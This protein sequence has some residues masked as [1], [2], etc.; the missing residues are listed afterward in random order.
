M[1]K[2]KRDIERQEV[3]LAAE[4]A[5]FELKQ[6]QWKLDREQELHKIEAD[7]A[8]QE[9]EMEAKKMEQ[10]AEME[11]KKMA[12]AAKK[13]KLQFEIAKAMLELKEA[14]ELQEL[15]NE[16]ADLKK[17]KEAITGNKSS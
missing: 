6:R 5:A 2:Q 8:E 4:K 17:K 7:K 16:L 1:Q 14:Q 13:E 12:A 15:E 9:A 3:K 11:A 10:D